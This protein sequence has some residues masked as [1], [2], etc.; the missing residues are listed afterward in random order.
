MFSGRR[1]SRPRKTA[2]RTKP[3]KRRNDEA[4]TTSGVP[5]SS[6][7]HLQT[8]GP[9]PKEGG[10]EDPATAKLAVPNVDDDE[11][12]PLN[13]DGPGDIHF[14][15]SY[16]KVADPTSDQ[17]HVQLTLE[18]KTHPLVRAHKPRMLICLCYTSKNLQGSTRSL[19]TT[20]VLHTIQSASTF[21]CL[22]P[23]LGPL[24]TSLHLLRSKK[25]RERSEPNAF[26]P[27][28]SN[29]KEAIPKRGLLCA[30]GTLWIPIARNLLISRQAFLYCLHAC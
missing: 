7:E 20:T 10:L 15:P 27:L 9:E 1:S 25:Q 21:P 3:S 29:T 19:M 13:Y 28:I 17:I 12:P 4:I 16:S 26:H 18:L 30:V 11:T 6:V 2:D 5:F 8:S 23:T 24:P 14:Y 22:K